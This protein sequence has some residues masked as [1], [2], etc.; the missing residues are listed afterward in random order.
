MISRCRIVRTDLQRC[1][2]FTL[3]EVIVTLAILG[4]VLVIVA[5]YK[6]PWSSGL[7]LKGTA[8]ELASGLRLARSEAI[9]G[10]RPVAFDLDVTGHLYR[11]GAGATRRLPANLSIELLT[12]TGENRGARVGDIRFNPDGSSSGGRIS[13]ADGKQR[14]AVG[15]DWLTGRVSVADV[16]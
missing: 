16:R 4:L 12:I 5:G 10:N 14:V 15:V 1:A 3:I 8:S 2:G 6:P 7:G 9:A 13:L 11:V